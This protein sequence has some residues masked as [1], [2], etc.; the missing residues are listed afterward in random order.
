MNGFLTLYAKQ[1]QK[2]P[3]YSGPAAAAAAKEVSTTSTGSLLDAG[4]SNKCR[5]GLHECAGKGKSPHGRERAERKP[6]AT[7]EP[8]LLGIAAVAALVNSFIYTGPQDRI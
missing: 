7:Q 5:E 4:F 1:P 3:I 6:C 8:I 2:C